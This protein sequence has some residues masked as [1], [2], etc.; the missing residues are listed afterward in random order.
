M[1]RQWYMWV[2]LVTVACLGCGGEPKGG[3]RLDVFPVSGEIFF[4]GEPAKDAM[5]LLHPETPHEVPEG[6]RPISSTA[7]VDENG[8]FVVSTYSSEDGAPAGKY[9]VTVTWAQAVGMSGRLDGPDKLKGRYSD[10]AQSTI[11]FEVA[12]SA[13]TVP[14]IELSAR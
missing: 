1:T 13:V 6:S 4:D 2:V 8:K 10:P 11:E 5:V 14:R 9:K 3:T 12:D 7:Q